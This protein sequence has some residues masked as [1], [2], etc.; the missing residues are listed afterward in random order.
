MG[1]RVSC[2]GGSGERLKPT[3]ETLKP[4]SQGESTYSLSDLPLRYVMIVDG[5][6]ISEQSRCGKGTFGVVHTATEVCEV[7]DKVSRRVAAKRSRK[8][9]ESDALRNERSILSN[10][11]HPHIIK[12]YGITGGPCPSQ[13]MEICDVELFSLISSNGALSEEVA[14]NYFRQVMM[15]L[16]YLHSVMRIVHRDIK[17]ENILL[18]TTRSVV[19]LCDFGTAVKLG[20]GRGS[21]ASGRTGSLSYAAPEV[22]VS[23]LSD[24][25]SDIWSAGVLLYVMKCG[26]SPFRNPDDANP[27]KAAVERVK[28]GKL[29][30]SRPK[31]KD[32]SAGPKRLILKLLQVDASQRPNAAEVLGDRWLFK[33]VEK[34]KLENVGRNVAKCL[35][36]FTAIG[37]PEIRACW[38]GLSSQ[39]GDWDHAREMFEI[40]DSDMDGILGFGDLTLLGFPSSVSKYTFSYSEFTAALLLDLDEVGRRELLTPIA[41]FA[42]K[43]VGSDLASITDFASFKRI[44]LSDVHYST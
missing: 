30:T 21:R 27:E 25:S 42:F 31:W 28:R 20:T 6:T 17:P 32:M 34:E 18:N 39:M 19:K 37:D 2:F 23:S 35:E 44:I 33:P 22:Y 11:D 4:S 3:P 5:S 41:P 15:A 14:Q 38:L 40:A 36:K 7:D 12:I 29:N 13:I 16:N 8:E 26:A 9:T 24:F 43:A 1:A 10:L